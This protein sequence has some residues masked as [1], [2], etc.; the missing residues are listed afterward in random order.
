MGNS[1]RVACGERNPRSQRGTLD[2]VKCL[3]EKERKKE[4]PAKSGRTSENRVVSIVFIHTNPAGEGTKRTCRLPE[5][6]GG[7]QVEVTTSG[8][9]QVALA[10]VADRRRRPALPVAHHCDHKDDHLGRQHFPY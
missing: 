8:L 5:V 4:G 3:S 10:S 1:P 9:I 6:A 2:S 7:A